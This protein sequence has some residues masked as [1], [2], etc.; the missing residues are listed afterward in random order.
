MIRGTNLRN[1]IISS[2][3]II[4]WGNLH[5]LIYGP[6]N[7]AHNVSIEP[8]TSNI[9]SVSQ[10]ISLWATCLCLYT[11]QPLFSWYVPPL[12]EW[13]RLPF[14]AYSDRIAYANAPSLLSKVSQFLIYGRLLLLRFWYTGAP[15][16]SGELMCYALDG[17][18]AISPLLLWKPAPITRVEQASKRTL[19]SPY[20]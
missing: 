15:I 4:I 19:S 13:V 5:W 17:Q 14:Q 2:H 7:L 1:R 9:K 11:Y 3:P 12:Y 6:N 18:Y 10:L 16:F 8:V 20:C